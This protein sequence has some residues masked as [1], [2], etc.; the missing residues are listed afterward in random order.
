MRARPDRRFWHIS[1][2]GIFFQGGAAAVD[3]STIVAALVHTLTGGSAF[4]VGTAAAISR[5]GWLF[6]QLLVAYY[7]QQRTSRLPFYVAGAFGRVACLIALAALVW[8]AAPSASRTIAL[9]FLIWTVYAFVSGIVAVPYNDIVARSIPSDRRSSMLALRFFCGGLLALAVATIAQRMLAALS[10]SDAYAAVL[11][12]GAALLFVSAVSFVT[13]REPAAPS[14]GRIDRGFAD[15]LRNGMRVL[16][17]DRHF[18]LFIGAQWL[19]GAAAL[20]LP[21]YVLLA[22]VSAADVAVLLGAQ[23]T[24]ALLS[25]PLWGWWGDRLGKRSL[26]EINAAFGALP[27]LLALAWIAGLDRLDAPTLSYFA[28]VFALLGATGNGGTIAQLGYLMEISPDDQR[29]A[30][31]GYFNALVAPVTLPMAGG[32]MAQA[33]NSFAAVFAIGGAAAA[34]QFLTV[35]RLR[36]ALPERG[37]RC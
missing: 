34:L 11:L 35:R 10:A 33:L 7:A 28:V 16:R 27:P 17:D 19:G 23:T 37:W 26:L 9:F 14:A 13:A 30:Y 4:A 8:T 18:R 2:A 24:G 6:P 15:F 3:T 32:A 25:N 12:I 21:F 36:G 5:F 29:P 20:A 22:N 31:S 1:V